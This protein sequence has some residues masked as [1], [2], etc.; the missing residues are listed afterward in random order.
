MTAQQPPKNPA[1]AAILSFLFSGIG[2]I[3]NGEVVKGII[4]IAVQIVNALLMTIIIGFITWPIVWIW[5]IYDAYKVAEKINGEAA[6]QSVANTKP[7]PQC[8]ER[9]QIDAKACWRCGYQLIPEPAAIAAPPQPLYQPAGFVPAQA[10]PTLPAQPVSDASKYCPQCGN[11][12]RSD[13]RFCIN[14]GYS[15][16]SS[17]AAS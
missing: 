5:S 14:C 7:C 4:I 8:A 9:I 17:P 10:A 13:A 11:A 2:Q 1:L 12:N 15:F 6:Q 16:T 3:Y